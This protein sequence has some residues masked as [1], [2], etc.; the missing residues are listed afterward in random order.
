MHPSQASD[1]Q[2]AVQTAHR[3]ECVF[4]PGF[5]RLHL[6]NQGE[7]YCLT[8]DEVERAAALLGP[9]LK[10]VERDGYCLD[11]DRIGDANTPDVVDAEYWLGL[12]QGEAMQVVGLASEADYRRVYEQIESAVTRRNNRQ[13]QTGVHVPIV[14]KKRGRRVINV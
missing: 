8:R 14:L 10:R 4:G 12:A 3:A 9:L 2:L 13:G 6:E 7:R 1:E 11:G 5:Y